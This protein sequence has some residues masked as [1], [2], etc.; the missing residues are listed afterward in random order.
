MG[1]ELLTQ[2][3]NTSKERWQG[4]ERK[5]S[6]WKYEALFGLGFFLIDNI[7]KAKPIM[8]AGFQIARTLKNEPLSEWEIKLITVASGLILLSLY[9]PVLAVLYPSNLM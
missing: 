6:I 1:L 8:R 4:N 3:F 2:R 5:F 9:V 7:S